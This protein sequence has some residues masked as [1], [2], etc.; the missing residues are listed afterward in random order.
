MN[1]VIGTVSFYKDEIYTLHVYLGFE[2]R[3]FLFSCINWDIKFHLYLSFCFF[4]EFSLI[5]DGNIGICLGPQLWVTLWAE[6][7][8]AV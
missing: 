6:G 8:S 5:N 4:H 1:S 3:E 7:V 2:Y